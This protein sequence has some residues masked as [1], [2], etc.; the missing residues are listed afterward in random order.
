MQATR[1]RR[2]TSWTAVIAWAGVIFWFS[3][4]TGSQVPG[5][6]GSFGHFGEYAIFGALILLA[7]GAPDRLLPTV[8]LASAYGITDEVHQLFVS[9]RQADPVDWLV[10]TLGALAGALVLSWLWRHALA[11][12]ADERP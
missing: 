7:L 2:I 8:A 1:A 9:G 3:S 12:R 11:R 4:L 5:R 10:D 6:Y